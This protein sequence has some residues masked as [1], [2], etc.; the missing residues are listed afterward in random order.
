MDKMTC[1]HCSRSFTPS[2]A[3]DGEPE[4]T[5]AAGEVSCDSCLCMVCGHGHPTETEHL[6]CLGEFADGERDA[7]DPDAAYEALRDGLIGV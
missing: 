3:P 2:T 7:V 6:F 4:Y 5:D 1:A